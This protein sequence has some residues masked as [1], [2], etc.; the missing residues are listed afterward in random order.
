[1]NF[2]LADINLGLRGLTPH[3]FPISLWNYDRKIFF[4]INIYVFSGV[5]ME[6]GAGL[7]KKVNNDRLVY[8]KNAKGLN[9]LFPDILRPHRN[10]EVPLLFL[11]LH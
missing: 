11:W 5:L 2:C 7:T 3:H 6:S 9:S 1:M 4:V 8:S 10:H